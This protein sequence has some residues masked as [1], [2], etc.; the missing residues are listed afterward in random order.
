MRKMV[1]KIA[2]ATLLAVI[3]FGCSESTKPDKQVAAPQFSPE[4]GTY[5][6]EKQVEI[7][8]ATEGATIRYTLDDSEPNSGSAIYS[9]PIPVSSDLIIKAKAYKKGWT[10]SP[11]VS[12]TYTFVPADTLVAP[13]FSPAA[14]VYK[15]AQHVS[16]SCSSPDAVIRYT[17]DGEEPDES[18]TLYVSPIFVNSSITLKAKAFRPEAVS[19]PTTSGIYSIAQMILVSGG[20]FHNGVSNVTL[21]SFY[22]SN[23]EITQAQYQAVVGE[24]PSHFTDRPDH[25]VE[26][27]SWSEA[28]R[29][30]NLRS[31][32]EGLTPCYSWANIGVNVDEWPSNWIL[33]SIYHITCD[34]GADG[35]RLPTEM[36]WMYA[37]LGGNQSHNYPYSGGEVLSEVAWYNVN[38]N[39]C[40]HRVGSKAPNEL[41]LYDLSGN[42]WE[43]V[44]DRYA[45]YPTAEQTDPH[46]PSSGS[47]LV[48]RG[49]SW[50]DPSDFCNVA[51]RFNNYGYYANFHIGFRVVRKH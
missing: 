31:Q 13:V 36:E 42:V 35:Y 1:L 33:C 5:S 26:N 39:A 14:G 46:G 27:V 15:E 11:V 21:S 10:A 7:S 47:Y 41:G 20:A 34:W 3:A 6:L 45:P 9:E 44:W 24:N 43:W 23:Y 17:T 50:T 29:Y 16:I 19:S 22:I 48:L 2:L 4:S 30:C 25:P 18:S 51:F 40:T 32:Q 8:C 28:I 12:A 37:A 49:G 38:S